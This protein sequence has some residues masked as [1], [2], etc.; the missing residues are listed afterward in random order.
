MNEKKVI[1]I[2]I[3]Y[4]QKILMSMVMGMYLVLLLNSGYNFQMFL[5]MEKTFQ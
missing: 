2:S 4:E 1:N 5:L 3:T